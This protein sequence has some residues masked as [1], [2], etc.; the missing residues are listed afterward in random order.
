MNEHLRDRLLRKLDTLSDE[1]GY[2]ALDYI[3]FLEARYA[4]RPEAPMTILGKFT[5]GVEDT[6]R[7]GKV[8]AKAIG[9]TMSLLNKAVG[10]LNGAAAAGKSVA[11]DL[12]GTASRVVTGASAAASA[13]VAAA[14]AAATGAPPAAGQPAAGTAAAPSA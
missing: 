8:S 5:D 1:R 14:S 7:A 4:T 12:K 11:S 9:E 10:V 6:L 2:Q 3:E 13:A